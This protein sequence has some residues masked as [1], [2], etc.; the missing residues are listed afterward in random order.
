MVDSDQAYSHL[1]KQ[2]WLITS[3]QPVKETDILDTPESHSFKHSSDCIPASGAKSQHNIAAGA[4][5]PDLAARGRHTSRPNNLLRASRVS[6]LDGDLLSHK[7]GVVA[8]DVAQIK[9]DLVGAHVK[10]VGKD[11]L[12]CAGGVEAVGVG[13]DLEGAAARVGVYVEG[14]GVVAYCA[15]KAVGPGD[16]GS[17]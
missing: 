12:G 9:P 13:G 1:L 8:K 16:V 6:A 3:S 10:I 7:G 15:G 4:A 17:D 2:S 14:L 5:N 11:G